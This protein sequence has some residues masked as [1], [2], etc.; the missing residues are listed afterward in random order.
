MN[1][2]DR[3]SIARRESVAYLD[4]FVGPKYR[5]QTCFGPARRA[6]P[7]QSTYKYV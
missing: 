7:K 5:R 4:E 2:R 6:D 1:K 3:V